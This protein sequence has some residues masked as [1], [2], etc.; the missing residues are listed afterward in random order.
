MAKKE[1]KKE[2]I[3]QKV[4][5]KKLK[6]E[7]SKQ[8]KQRK[9][10]AAYIKRLENRAFRE[11]WYKL[12]NAAT[13]YPA[14]CSSNWN[15]VFRV[16][17]ELK[18]NIDKDKLQQALDLTVKRYPIFNVCIRNGLFWHYFQPV[19]GTPLV[20]EEKEYPCQPF[21]VNKK[22]ALI[23]VLYYNNKICFEIFHALTDG[24]GATVF[25]N[26]LLTCYLELCGNKI[27]ISDKRFNVQD[28]FVE[29]EG[30][31]AFRQYARFDK[32]KSRKEHKAFA[33][34]GELMPPS[35]LKIIKGTASVA[36]VKE[37]AKTFDATVNEFLSAIYINSMLMQKKR[38]KSSKLPVKL[39]VP[40]NLRRHF[41]T[42]TLKN[43]SAYYNLELPLD[44]EDVD[45]ATLIKIIQ[46]QKATF[47][48]EFLL[49]FLSSNVKSER[50][51]FVRI[52][53]LS[54]KDFVLKM[55]YNFLGEVLYTSTISNIGVID[56]PDNVAKHI[57]SYYVSLGS[58]KLNR[59]NL[60]VVSL[61]D[62]MEMCFTSRLK[63]NQ[64]MQDFF[65]QLASFGI[66]VEV[67]TNM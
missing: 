26:T 15:Y 38:S 52:M 36:K 25:F 18:K 8:A 42:R 13:I 44:K 14:I 2:K 60:A 34:E 4:Q 58:T 19:A 3:E 31:D 67:E 45:F 55:V 37:V 32:T 21:N 65:T 61:N 64:I 20:E 29:E 33:V 7:L 49:R 57:E 46:Q 28:N 24:Y 51:F 53:P 48:D 40:V 12:D 66:D 10:E 9:K 43:F 35:V 39:S 11:N 30:E 17:A 62:K 41:E 54:I 50:N 22:Q 27:A 47:N 5:A 63:S 1:Q 59:F 56:L 6:K 23:R 16:S